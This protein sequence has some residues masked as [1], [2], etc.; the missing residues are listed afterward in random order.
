MR[1]SGHR[2]R[3]ARART[4]RSTATT[5]VTHLFHEDNRRVPEDD[6]LTV[7]HGFRGAYPNALFEVPRKDFQA[8]VD[9]VATL[10]HETAYAALRRRFGVLRSSDRFWSYSDQIIADHKREGIM[11]GLFDYNRLDGL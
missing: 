1:R 11:A 2:S 5:N 6:E 4:S 3:A 8:F 10:E 7:V 9:A